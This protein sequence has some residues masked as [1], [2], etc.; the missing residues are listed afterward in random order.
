MKNENFQNGISL[1]PDDRFSDYDL[2]STKRK[3]KFF[4]FGQKVGQKFDVYRYGL[5]LSRV[6]YN[7]FFEF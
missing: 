5:F 7:F 2:H 1:H 3:K 4:E 6:Y